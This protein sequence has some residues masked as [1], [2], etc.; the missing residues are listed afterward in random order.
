MDA[1]IV[2][3][4]VTMIPIVRPEYL[5]CRLSEEIP[6]DRASMKVV[7]TVENTMIINPPNPKP[8]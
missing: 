8:A 6:A 5:V 1:P 4:M 7:V 2:P 3:M